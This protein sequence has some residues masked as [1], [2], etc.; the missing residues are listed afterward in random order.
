MNGSTNT[1]VHNHKNQ[2]KF[3]YLQI[4][5]YSHILMSTSDFTN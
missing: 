5:D 1:V 3:G 2:L 4:I